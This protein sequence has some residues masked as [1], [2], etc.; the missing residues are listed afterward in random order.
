MAGLELRI[1]DPESN[2]PQPANTEGEIVVRG[3]SL[4]RS[5]YRQSPRDCFDE[6]GYFHTGDCGVLDE[7]GNL[8]FIGRLKD[9]IKTAGVNVSAAEVEAV[10]LL[11]P[12]V[13]LAHVVPVPHPT[14]GE[15]VAGFIVQR[16]P[17][18]TEPELIEHCRARLASYKVPRHLF[19]V[20]EGELPIRG[21]GKVDRRELR[22]QA[23]MRVAANAER[24]DAPS[25]LP[26]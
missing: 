7:D 4:M 26:R 12:A 9:V 17:G 25:G 6:E 19:F 3:T 14:R 18:C 22:N 11:H 21:S 2:Q 5:Y 10:L 20:A 13:K 23:S 15:N 1:V 24:D 8:H 16:A